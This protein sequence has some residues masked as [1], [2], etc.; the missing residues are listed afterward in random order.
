LDAWGK[1]EGGPPM[2]M[3][4]QGRLNDSLVVQGTVQPPG[5]PKPVPALM[6]VSRGLSDGQL[7]YSGGWILD[8]A[9]LYENSVT[10]LTLAGSAR[11]VGIECCFDYDS[12]DDGLRD[13][14]A[15]AEL[16]ER[17]RR[18]ARPAAGPVEE[19]VESSVLSESVG[20]EILTRMQSGQEQDGESRGH[21]TGDE[22]GFVTNVP[23]DAPVL[24]LL[25]A[26]SAS[27]EVKFKT[28]A[29]LSKSVN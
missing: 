26:A 14:L 4:A 8:D 29:E 25:N 23:V 11:V 16:S 6:Y 10:A 27:D 19:L 21:V 2:T 20:R 7:V 17:E 15:R 22:Y 24:H 18:G 3:D 28:G 9:A 12:D 1:R 5:C 13:V